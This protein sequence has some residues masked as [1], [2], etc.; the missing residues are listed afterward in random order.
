MVNVPGGHLLPVRNY[1]VYITCCT[2][3]WSRVT[4]LGHH[5]V[6]QLLQILLMQRMWKVVRNRGAVLKYHVNIT[7]YC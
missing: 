1:A 5:T 7:L 3:L 2:A 6:M 4:E